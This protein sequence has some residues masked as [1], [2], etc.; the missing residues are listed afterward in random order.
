MDSNFSKTEPSLVDI[1]TEVVLS[2]EQL[3][4]AENINQEV[5]FNYNFDTFSF[6]FELLELANS[7]DLTLPQAFEVLTI[8]SLEL[9]QKYNGSNCAGLAM[10]LRKNLGENGIASVLIPCFGS[11]MPTPEADEYAGVRTVGLFTRTRDNR[12]LLAPGLTIPQAVELEESNSFA[13]FRTEYKVQK[14]YPNRFSLVAIK[15]D[16]EIIERI[17]SITEFI[18][19]DQ[20]SQ[21]NLLRARPKYQ[22]SRQHENGQRDYISFDFFKGTFKVAL[23]TQG[24]SATFSPQDFLEFLNVNANTLQDIFRNSYLVEGLRRFIMK[25]SEILDHILVPSIKN[26]LREQ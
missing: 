13:A 23:E 17:F 1:Q 25:R 20:S 9:S 8:N 14:V 11:Y 18:N 2:D 3:R 7:Q 5:V 26:K 24:I 19:P 16:G 4:I 12:F 6:I 15:P 10:L 22:I 21:K